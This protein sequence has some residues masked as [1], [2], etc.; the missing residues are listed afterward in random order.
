LRLLS[1][2]PL[3][4][5]LLLLL[6]LAAGCC[7]GFQQ[8]PPPPPPPRTPAHTPIDRRA[9]LASTA[10]AAAI[11]PALLL[12]LRPVSSAGA[13]EAREALAKAASKIP[14]YGPPD[15]LFPPFFAGEWVLTREGAGLSVAQ[16]G[17]ENAD[18]EDLKQAEQW[19]GERVS[20]PV[21]FLP[22]DE[23]KG[24]E[25]AGGGKVIADR[26]F[27]EAALWR[28]RIGAG[29]GKKSELY[30]DAI[31]PRWDRSN[32]NVLTVAFP[33]GVVREVKVTKRSVE[34]AG[35]EDAFGLSEFCRVAEARQDTGVASIPRIS[36]IRVL[37]RW[38]RTGPATVEGLEL[39]KY[40]P[41][42]S[43]DPNP[44]AVFTLKSRLRLE[45][46]P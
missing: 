2:T 45:R 1:P 3:L 33:D 20:Y 6:L 34:S 25:G 31:T 19:A 24:G 8:P 40:Y 46:R 9:A 41:P 42:V 23:E 18:A 27:N 12:L 13:S 35:G 39:I 11:A 15:T 14:G 5:L 29:R 21:R 37:Q 26:G 30:L 22:Y 17:K 36:A 7:S 10:G 38:K 4:L 43:L 44:P 32:P 16:G 28:A